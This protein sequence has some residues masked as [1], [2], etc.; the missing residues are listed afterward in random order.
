MRYSNWLTAI[1]PTL[2][3]LTILGSLLPLYRRF[4]AD[5]HA[6]GLVSKRG[7]ATATA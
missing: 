3:S 1:A 4:G 2:I 7:A 6:A 5:C